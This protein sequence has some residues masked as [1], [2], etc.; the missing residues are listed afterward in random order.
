VA[1]PLLTGKMIRAL[2]VIGHGVDLIPHYV[3]H[4]S[5]YVDE[6]Q[7]VVYQ[8]DRTPT[9]LD[10]V[11]EKIKDYTN[12]KIVKVIEN[13]VFDW[14][15]V[16][17]LYNLVKSEHPNDWWV[18]ADIDEFHL[19]PDD[20]LSHIIKSCEEYGYELLR[21]G[22][23][24]RIGPNGEFSE[25]K[26]DLTIWE[27]FPNMGF[28][29]YPLSNACPNKVC[30]MKGY[31]EITSGQHYAKIDGQTTW[32]WQG[33]NHPLI[34]PHSFVQVHHF[35]WDKTSMERIRAVANINQPY[36]YSEEYR[37]MYRALAKMRSKI[38]MTNSEFMI[39]G[40]GEKGKYKEYRQWNK[41]IKK[42]IAI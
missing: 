32:K 4:Y 6:I 29:R 20:N 38:D 24:D 37:K 22:F 13:R 10:E 31:I 12:V 41:L 28:F 25:L 1:L 14:E 27:Q 8:T 42:I 11:K 7:F 40:G 39:E 15:K 33:W 19:Y 21:G 30:V 16:T 34:N 23:I 18:I 3:K 5:Q 26:D 36:A 17:V 9:L 2:S 35:K